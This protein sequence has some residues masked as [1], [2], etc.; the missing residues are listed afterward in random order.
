MK[1]FLTQYIN[2]SIRR[3]FVSR[4][5]PFSRIHIRFYIQTI[6]IFADLGGGLLSKHSAWDP[7][8]SLVFS[9]HVFKCGND[10][11]AP[12]RHH[13]HTFCRPSCCSP[14]FPSTLLLPSHLFVALPLP[15]SVVLII[16]CNCATT[17]VIAVR[18][19]ADLP[20]FLPSA[21]RREETI[22]SSREHAKCHR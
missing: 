9:T 7:T 20:S 10:F 13:R 6:A 3:T 12:V 4:H 8:S 22:L 18:A 2:P 1:L 19:I 11:E 21:A 16:G 17:I 15:T 14:F 5:F